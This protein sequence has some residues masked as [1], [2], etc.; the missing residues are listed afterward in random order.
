[1][2]LVTHQIQHLKDVKKIVVLEH[3]KIRMQGTYSELREKGLDFD[4]ILE[5]Y[6]KK[7]ED[8]EDEII[9]DD[10]EEEEDEEANKS[11]KLP[12]IVQKRQSK[13]DSEDHNETNMCLNK[14]ADDAM[15]SKADV[16]DKK[17]DIIEKEKIEEGQIP[18]S[19]WF[20]F[21]NYGCSF[22]GIFLII[23]FGGLAIFFNI[24]IS[25]VVGIWAE[26]NKEDQK[27]PLYFG[28]F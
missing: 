16:R 12:P 9:L 25:F 26:R 27:D 1:V 6:N 14:E 28:I 11:T 21:F 5:G 13:Q 8:K 7:E 4:K 18:L 3:S 19:L 15:T 20:K 22:L 17:V 24:T 2:V 23:F 10:D